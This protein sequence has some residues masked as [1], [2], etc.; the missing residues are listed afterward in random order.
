[1]IAISTKTIVA[2]IDRAEKREIPQI[3]CPLV[4]PLLMPVP[5]PTNSPP[6]IKVG[7]DTVIEKRI[8]LL[9]KREYI[10]G[11]RINPIKNRRL[12]GLL[13]FEL[14]KLFRHYKF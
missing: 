6:M 10:K 3:P 9:E 2:S 5:I 14:I 8:S 7:K 11:P 13:L 12:S 4:Q 1:M